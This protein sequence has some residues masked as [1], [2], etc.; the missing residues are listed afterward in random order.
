MTASSSAIAVAGRCLRPLSRSSRRR[1]SD[2]A[3]HAQRDE[4]ERGHDGQGQEGKHAGGAHERRQPQPYPEP[5][6]G[7]EQPDHGRHRR[8]SRPQALPQNR[9]ARAPQRGGEQRTRAP[10]R[11]DAAQ[12]PD[13]ANWL[14]S[15]MAPRTYPDLYSTRQHVNMRAGSRHTR[16]AAYANARLK[17]SAPK[18]CG[19]KARAAGGRARS[20]ARR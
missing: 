10:A 18:P 9:P 4:W 19:V 20:A 2:S 14:P 5:G 6:H 7:Q 15:Q 17:P 16:P 12:E 3:R 13:W 11:R 8:Q 1:P